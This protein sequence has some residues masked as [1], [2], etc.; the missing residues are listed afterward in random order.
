MSVCRST[1]V[2][3]DFSRP[4]PGVWATCALA[5]LLL[6]PAMAAGPVEYPRTLD[7]PGGTVVVHHPTVSDWK[8]FN[9]LS[10]W[11]PVEISPKGSSTPWS[12]SVMVQAVSEIRFEERVVQLSGLR[13]VKAVA[14]ESMPEAEQSLKSSPGAY[15]LL[16]DALKQAQHTLSLEYLLRALPAD[17]ADSLPKPSLPPGA[18]K[19]PDI[20]LSEQP[21]VLVL[22]DGPPQT[23]PIRNSQLEVVVNSNW[24]VLHDTAAEVW[25]MVFGD[26]WLRNDNLTGGTWQVASSVPSDIENLAMANGFDGLKKLLPPK[27][28]D[29]VPPPFKF[30]YEP[31][32]LVLFDG[33]PKLQPLPGT[34]LQQV[35]N[36]DQDL[37]FFEDRYYLLL[38]GRWFSARDLKGGWSFVDDLP[39]AF[40]SIPASSDKA[41]VLAAVPGTEEHR[42]ALIEAA[43]PRSRAVPSASGQQ[44]QVRYDGEP[45][46]AFISGTP[47]ERATNTRSQVLRVNEF[48]YLCED[49]AWYRSAAATGPW[50]AALEIPDAVYD[51][52]PDDPAYPVTFVKLGSFDN[53]TG[54]QA[55]VHT[56][57]YSGTYTADKGLAEGDGPTGSGKYYDP[58]YDPRQRDYAYWGSFG[59]GGFY[60]PY[61]YGARYY[62][63]AGGWRYG[64]YYD[65]FWGYPYPYPMST[66][67]TYDVPEKGGGDWVMGED[68]QKYQPYTRPDKNYVGSGEYQQDPNRPAMDDSTA[69]AQWYSGPDGRLYRNTGQGWEVQQG[70]KWFP[71]EGPVPEEVEREYQA[72]QAGYASYQRFKEEM[73]QP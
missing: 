16:Q 41:H 51:I 29:R 6:N 70:K 48:Y 28:T 73:G 71:L 9:V 72:R 55:Y 37:F 54:R 42:I 12:G 53:E 26:Y 10:A 5:L 4:C 3:K 63:W 52:P 39:T 21:A 44:V 40:A 15:P 60:P 49:A 25:Y 64:G 32:E 59:Y 65:P 30:S 18:N 58:T 57:G 22:F 35:A 13:P 68:G 11:V 50:K 67:T 24:L 45:Q 7:L 34:S 66:S 17:F 46:F 31:A 43:L 1:A 14:D 33:P 23:A 27:Q 56:Y 69:A 38:A 19:A 2:H 36:S 20:M 61:G 8:D 62:P 47:L